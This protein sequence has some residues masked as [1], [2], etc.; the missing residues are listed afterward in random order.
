MI[1]ELLKEPREPFL[2]IKQAAKLLR[3]DPRKLA[4]GGWARAH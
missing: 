1:A 4:P 3:I 2:T